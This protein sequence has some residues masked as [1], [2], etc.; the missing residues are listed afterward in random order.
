MHRR[1]YENPR[2]KDSEWVNV[3][4]Y[5]LLNATHKTYKTVFNGN[6]IDLK[7]GQLV[8]GR[9]SISKATGINESKVRRIL[10]ILKTDH[11]IDQQAGNKSSLVSILNWDKYQNSD[12]QNDQQLT[13]NRPTTDQQPTTYKNDK[14]EENDKNEENKIV[15][16]HEADPAP[17]LTL[18]IDES[19]KKTS[20]KA[21]TDEEWLESLKTNRAYEGIDITIEWDKAKVWCETHNKHLTR[22]RFVNW[23]NRTEKPMQVNGHKPKTVIDPVT[24]EEYVPF[25]TPE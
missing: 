22:R 8:T 25:F 2:T 18:S 6:V 10:N 9:F 19:T 17:Q 1:L 12:Q 11:Q 13:S 15:G 24:G 7:P 23:I 14:K 20:T 5:L 4:L 16:Q 3:W 21:Q